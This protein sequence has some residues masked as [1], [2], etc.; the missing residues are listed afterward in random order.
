MGKS[1]RENKP[2][3]YLL[4]FNENNLILV[5][6]FRSFSLHRPAKVDIYFFLSSPASAMLRSMMVDSSSSNRS[7]KQRRQK[8]RSR[9]SLSQYPA[10][11]GSVSEVED[12]KEMRKKNHIK[13][14]YMMNDWVSWCCMEKQAKWIET[15]L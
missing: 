14:I 6:F 9:N 11:K 1:I 13:Y 5:L 3:Q 4:E 10:E 15:K 8:N 12:D 2:Q 7:S